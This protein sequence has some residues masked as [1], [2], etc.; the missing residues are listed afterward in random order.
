MKT[1]SQTCS[2][3]IIVDS[4]KQPCGATAVTQ[5]ANEKDAEAAFLRAGWKKAAG[6][7]VCPLCSQ[8]L[9]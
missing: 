4:T 7:W 5:A 3:T 2:K 8:G 1:F 6:K 9:R